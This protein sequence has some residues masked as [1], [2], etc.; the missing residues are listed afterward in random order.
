MHQIKNNERKSDKISK[1][2]PKNDFKDKI[3]LKNSDKED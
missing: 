1:N 3:K 2:I